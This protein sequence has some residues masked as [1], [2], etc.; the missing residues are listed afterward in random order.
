MH[1]VLACIQDTG[2][3]TYTYLWYQNPMGI[4]LLGENYVKML[5]RSV[6]MKKDG[7]ILV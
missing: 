6:I 7:G 2:R 1:T 4:G 3:H 5:L